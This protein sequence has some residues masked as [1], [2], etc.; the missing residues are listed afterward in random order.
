MEQRAGRRRWL[1]IVGAVVAVLAVALGTAGVLGVREATADPGTGM[2]RLAHLSPT[3]PAL[4]MYATGPNLPLVKVAGDV[5]YR[6]VSPYLTE[7]AGTYRI[8]GR[9][10]GA[11][12]SSAPIFDV[13][14]DLPAGSA[15]TATFVDIGPGGTTQAQVLDDETAPAA[16]GVGSI[17]SQPA[18]SRSADTSEG[19]ARSFSSYSLSSATRN[20]LILI[21]EPHRSEVSKMP[22]T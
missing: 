14:V 10:A 22:Q 12:A 21:F 5:S 3:T 4:D 20:S 18:S 8:Q 7:P 19:T 15:Q 2:L 9:P 6:A 16:S 11:P 17:A 1:W 13:A